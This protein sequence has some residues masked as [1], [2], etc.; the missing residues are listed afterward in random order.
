[1]LDKKD[2]IK[3]KNYKRFLEEGI[4]ELLD[5][6]DIKKALENVKGKYK[7]E[8]RSLII[9]FYC[10]GARPNEILRLRSKD[11][12]RAK[13][14]NKIIIK[15]Q[16]SKNGLPREMIFSIRKLPLIKELYNYSMS[17]FQEQFLFYHFSDHY[18]RTKTLKSGEVRQYIE[19]SNKLRYHFNKWFENVIDD[20]IPP[21]YLRHNRF[22]KMI[23]EGATLEQIRL[24][25]G[26][27]TVNSVYPYVHMS[28]EIASK[29]SKYID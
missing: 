16:S 29:A 14:G 21:Y 12:F 4:I 17:I 6:E 27:K 15:L 20:S 10:T 9:A 22:S 23:K 25:K 3:N 18:V 11:I 26:A 1:M 7:I 19:I 8:G 24:I 13:V 28:K 5:Q 2:K